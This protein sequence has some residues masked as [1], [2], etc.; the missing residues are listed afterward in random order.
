MRHKDYK[1][2]VYEAPELFY[3]DCESEGVLCQS[4]PAMSE[5]WGDGGDL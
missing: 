5:T 1:T 3:L 4:S 2:R